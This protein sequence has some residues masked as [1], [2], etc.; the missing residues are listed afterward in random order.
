MTL[1]TGSSSYKFCCRS[2]VYAVLYN[3]SGSGEVDADREEW[4]KDSYRSAAISET[5]SL[6]GW[7]SE[8]SRTEGRVLSRD[9]MRICVSWLVTWSPVVRCRFRRRTW[10]SKCQYSNVCLK[11]CQALTISTKTS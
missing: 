3:R 2:S 1:H 11:Y 9:A 10:E 8:S 7:P 6:G 4:R 5:K